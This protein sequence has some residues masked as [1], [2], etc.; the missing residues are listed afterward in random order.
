MARTHYVAIGLMLCSALAWGRWSAAKNPQ[1]KR[2]PLVL[3]NIGTVS[4]ETGEEINGENKG[5]LDCASK[6]LNPDFPHG[7]TSEAFQKNLP[8]KSKLHAIAVV[9]GH[10]RSGY[11]CSGDGDHCGK[12]NDQIVLGFSNFPFW[13]E[14]VQKSQGKFESLTLLGCDIGQDDEGANLL[15]HVAETVQMPVRAPDSNIFCDSSGFT[16]DEGGDWV[17]ATP[18]SRPSVHIGRNYPV[19]PRGNFIFSVDSKPLP[20]PT[21]AIKL[22][23]FTHRTIQE[24]KFRVVS[25]ETASLTQIV[26]FGSYF[27]VSGRPAAVL[28]GTFRIEINLSGMPKIERTFAL[29]NDDL[30]EDLSEQDAFYR[31]DKRRLLQLVQ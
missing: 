3:E 4:I 15:F 2:R 24:E 30:V 8:S 10:G 31:A 11:Q 6:R 13:K 23:E 7:S 25:L 14:F 20:I 29:F 27:K 17:V 5:F 16:F 28:T 21:T 18:T 22:L 26:D 9:V 19:Q 12:Y 1:Q